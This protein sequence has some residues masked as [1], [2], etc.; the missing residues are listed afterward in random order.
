MSDS[1]PALW[2]SLR[3]ASIAIVVAALVAIP[4]A[5]FTARRVF[6]GRSLLDALLMLP[7]VLPPTVVG[8]FLL[9]LGSRTGW[10]GQWIYDWLG[11]SM[12][13]RFEGAVLAAAVVAFPL[14]YI[15]ARSAFASMDR[16][17]E[18]VAR[19]MGASRLG[20]FFHVTLPMAMRG[21]G[22]GL[23]LGFARAMGEFGA[24]LM[25]YSFGPRRTTLPILIWTYN[26]KLGGMVDALPAVLMLAGVSALVMLIH[27]RSRL[28]KLD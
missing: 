16:E 23:L 8:Y 7:I 14:L 21:I 26:E 17:L 12:L 24:T 3:I 13:F 10:P 28:G 22:G 1:L 27:N 4:L 5:H 11:Y 18:E 9:M 15:P 2:L 6:F 20:T 19:L 25:V